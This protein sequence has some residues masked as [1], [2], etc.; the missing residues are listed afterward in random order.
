M[1]GHVE[2]LMDQKSDAKVMPKIR[3]L[4]KTDVRFWK[5]SIFRRKRGADIDSNWTVQ[6]QFLKRREQFP[7]DTPNKDAAAAKARDIYLSLHSRGWEETLLLCKPQAQPVEAKPEQSN[8]GDLIREVSATT[9][10]RVTT[11]SVYCAALR[12]IAADLLKIKGGKERFAAKGKGNKKWRELVD[13]TPLALITA[14]AI[15]KWKL[16]YLNARKDSPADHSRAVNTVNAH[17]RNARSLFTAKALE[18]A[19]KRLALPDPL[20][21]SDVKLERRRATTRYSSRIDPAVL[22]GDAKKELSETP[23]CR[24]QF[25]IFCLALLCGLR[26]REIDTLLWTSVDFEKQVIRIE[27]TRYF[28]PKSEESVAEVDLAPELAAIFQSY[29]KNAKG[30]FVIESENPPR[31]HISRANYRAEREFKSLYAWLESKG[32]SARKKLH[33]L[34]KECGSVIANSMGIFAASRALRHSDIRITSQYYSDKKVRI[35][36]GLDTL[37]T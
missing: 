14:E 28:Q 23:G 22:I 2:I 34:R 30:E 29:R 12:R 25:K 4:A 11:F 33:E 5:E 1:S 36:T 21:F 17:L 3:K 13:A 20:P 7:L 10:Y 9:S 31:Y 16:Q 32:V 19:G 6:I 35:T 18:F 8:I 27:R 24:E 26:K 15:Q 37:L